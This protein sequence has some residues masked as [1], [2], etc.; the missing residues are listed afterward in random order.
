[1]VALSNKEQDVIVKATSAS[2]DRAAM[3]TVWHEM[4]IES[5]VVE[6]LRKGLHDHAICLKEVTLWH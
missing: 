2:K 6:V 4:T 1:M 5:G 3:V